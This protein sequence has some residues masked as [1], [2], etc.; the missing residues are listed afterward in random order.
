METLT[1]SKDEKAALLQFIIDHIQDEKDG[2]AAAKEDKFAAHILDPWKTHIEHL[3][4]IK[5][6]LHG[7]KK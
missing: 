3:D 2:Y 5:A 7:F 6:K 4:T 1:L